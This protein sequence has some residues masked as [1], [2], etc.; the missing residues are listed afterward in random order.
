LVYLS[1]SSFLVKDS[2]TA[3]RRPNASAWWLAGF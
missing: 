2:E 1:S 3:G